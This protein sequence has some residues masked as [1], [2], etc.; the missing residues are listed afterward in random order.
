MLSGTVVTMALH[1]IGSWMENREY[2]TWTVADN[3]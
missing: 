1:I 3:R 2:V